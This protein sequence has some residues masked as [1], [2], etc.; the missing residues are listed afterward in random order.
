MIGLPVLFT[1]TAARSGETG[2]WA[3]PD[4]GRLSMSH[5]RSSNDGSFGVT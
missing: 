1:S 4:P 2:G 5:T 3:G